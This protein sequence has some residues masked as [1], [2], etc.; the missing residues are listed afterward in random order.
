[1]T[2]ELW[3]DPGSGAASSSLGNV[4][5]AGGASG[6]YCRSVYPCSSQV[7]NT[8]NISLYSGASTFEST[9][10]AG[11]FTGF[12]TM[13]AYGGASGTGTGVGVGGAPGPSP[14]GG[15]VAN[16]D[17]NPGMA[18]SNDGS[19]TLGYGGAVVPGIYGA[20]NPGAR[21]SVTSSARPGRPAVC[22]VTFS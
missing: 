18:G 12:T 9:V 5:G 22:V 14:V 16:I 8:L 15:N 11:S 4:I 21:G 10:T 7:G 1:M 20:G 2:V 6:G 17:G 19:L 3:A 13:G